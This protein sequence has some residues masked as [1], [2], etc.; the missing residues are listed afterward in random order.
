MTETKYNMETGLP[1]ASFTRL[2]GLLQTT[3]DGKPSYVL[4]DELGRPELMEWHDQ[5]ELHRDGAAAI[6]HFNPENNIH[7][8]EVYY[9]HGVER[10]A[11]D[12][13]FR[14]WRDGTTGKITKKEFSV[15]IGSRK[16]VN[17]PSPS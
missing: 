9:T 7:T 10:D 16:S 14:V 2:N 5:G 17:P 15:E 4:F 1:L 3:P 12:G 13:P 8:L 11:H 6:V